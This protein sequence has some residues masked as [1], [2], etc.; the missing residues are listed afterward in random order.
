MGR[1]Q[2][3]LPFIN[4]RNV[5]IVPVNPNLPA[6]LSLV[7]GNIWCVSPKTGSDVNASGKNW[8]APFKTLAKAL[9]AATANQNDIVLYAGEGNA[10]GNCTDY[11]GTQLNWNKDMVHLIG[12]NSGVSISPRAR[13]AAVSTWTSANP[14]VKISANGC[15]IANIGIFFG[16]ADA[17][18]LGALTVT[19]QRNRFENCHITGFGN[20]ANDI[21]GAY[22]ILLDGADE[23]EFIR[24]TIGNDRIQCGAQAN[25]RILC[26][27][28]AKNNSFI[29]SVIKMWTSHATNHLFLRAP[30]SSLQG[31]LGFFNT[32]GINSVHITG[33]AT[34]TYGAVVASTALGDVFFDAMSGFQ[35][36]DVNSTDAGNVYG[37]TAAGSVFVP[38]V[39]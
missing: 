35:A 33:G 28:G 39:K 38:L 14:L 23:N 37:P 1:Q 3:Q 27:N 17:T 4:T 31:V 26:A 10:S 20:A 15:Y 5:G 16:V 22:D 34:L 36:T 9:N 7:P 25:S 19:G 11:Q 32:V 13:I 18:G 6:F 2:T 21:S 30:A 8:S 29:N 24:C 12:I